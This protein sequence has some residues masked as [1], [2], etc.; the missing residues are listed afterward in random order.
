METVDQEDSA[1]LVYEQIPVRNVWF[2]F[3]YAHDLA[4]FHG[5]F[6]AEIEDSPDLKSLIARLLCRAVQKRL[7]RNLS[8]GY[9]RRKSVLTRVRGRIDVLRT[10]TEG[11]LARG[12]IACRFEELTIDT[13]RNR[14]VWAALSMLCRL[15]EDQHMVQ[16]TRLL[17]GALRA[18]GVGGIRPSRSEVASDQLAR[19][20]SDDRLMVSLARAVFEI[21]L[22]TESEGIR[23]LYESDREETKFRKLFERAVGNFLSIELPYEDGWRV[24]PGKHF[25]WPLGERTKA[26]NAHMPIM[27]TDIVVDNVLEGRRLVIDTKFTDVFTKSIY[28]HRQR[29]KSRHI[30]QLYAYLRSQEDPKDPRSLCSEGLLL[31][32]AVGVTV[33]ERVEIQGHVIRF[34]TVDLGAPTSTVF[35]RLRDLPLRKDWRQGNASLAVKKNS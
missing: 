25:Q 7:R 21:V 24:Y 30:F 11:L 15:L 17:A 16:R 26:I 8:F 19:H 22:P 31:Y 23:A 18:A 3:L 12:Q 6:D 28:D 1:P 27:I 34:A 29:F 14:F 20:E 33:D 5:R 2:L 4:R 13:P 10:E 35:D 32:P 9:Q